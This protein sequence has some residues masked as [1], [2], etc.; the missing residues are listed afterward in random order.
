ML[1]SYYMYTLFIVL[2][3]LP[4]LQIESSVATLHLE[5]LSGPFFQQYYFKNKGNVHCFLGTMLSPHI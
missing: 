4:F 2:Q 5:N 1:H 3:I